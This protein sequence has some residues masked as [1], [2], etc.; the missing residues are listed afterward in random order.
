MSFCE[1]ILSASHGGL[2]P[3]EKSVIDRCI[4]KIY[5]EYLK[6]PRPEAMPVL[7]DLY[8]CL[9]SQEEGQAQELATKTRI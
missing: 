6:N 5:R 3:I 8:Q 2:K 9:R 7:G 4:P 1:L